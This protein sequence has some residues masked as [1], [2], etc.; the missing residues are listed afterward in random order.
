MLVAVPIALGTGYYLH[1]VEAQP[2]ESSLPLPRYM[3]VPGAAYGYLNTEK[4]AREWF[5]YPGGVTIP[6]DWDELDGIDASAKCL[7]RLSSELTKR[8]YAFTMSRSGN[9]QSPESLL[10]FPKTGVWCRWLEYRVSREFMS[11]V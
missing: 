5:A 1:S 8:K 2:S 11:T 7:S 4:Y 9:K 6:L 10:A 3:L